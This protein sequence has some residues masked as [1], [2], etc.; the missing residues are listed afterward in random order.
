MNN[1]NREVSQKRDTSADKKRIKKIFVVA[2]AVFAVLLL[3]AAVIPL[4]TELFED[5]YD[6]VSYNPMAFYEVDYN[7]DVRNDVLY[8]KLNRNVK[9]NRYGNERVLSESN[10]NDI[11]PSAVLFFNYFNCIINGNSESYPSFF[12][13]KCKNDE[14]FDLPERFTTQG[15]YDMNVNFHS[16]S[17]KEGEEDTVLEIYEV[18]YRI[19][20]NN[21]SFRNDIL[22]DETRTLVFEIEIKNGSALINAVGRRS[23]KTSAT[24]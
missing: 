1:K 22:P 10:V 6:D 5:D 19:F 18:S 14:K 13:E 21:G 24:E 23:D 3:I 11:S 20:K 16:A 8:Q 7:F 15:L 2:T 12:T 4:V 9:Y 17:R